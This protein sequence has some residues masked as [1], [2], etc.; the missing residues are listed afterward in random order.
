M[1]INW[2]EGEFFHVLTAFDEFAADLFSL[3]D[4]RVFFGFDRARGANPVGRSRFCT[5]LSV[6]ETKD[7]RRGVAFGSTPQV[8]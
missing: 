4:I 2:M 1:K 6:Q 8:K 7:S 5:V 3:L